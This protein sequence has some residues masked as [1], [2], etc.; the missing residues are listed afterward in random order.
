MW[1]SHDN[2]REWL[3][4]VKKIKY[5]PMIKSGWGKGREMGRT[6]SN[7]MG[8]RIWMTPLKIWRKW[9]TKHSNLRVLSRSL[10]FSWGKEEEEQEG[11]SGDGNPT[12][13]RRVCCVS[14]VQCRYGAVAWPPRRTHTEALCS[15]LLS[16]AGSNRTEVRP[17]SAC[18]TVPPTCYCQTKVMPG[19]GP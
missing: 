3:S 10:S 12:I 4:A 13:F 6:T 7:R 2:F 1:G 16:H 8:A 19:L 15:W 9:C 17:C 14:G 5:S 18:R 11:S